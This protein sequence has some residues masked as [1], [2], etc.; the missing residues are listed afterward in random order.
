MLSV[1]PALFRQSSSRAR[2]TDASRDFVAIRDSFISPAHLTKPERWLLPEGQC[3]K[4]WLIASRGSW[5]FVTLEVNGKTLTFR[6]FVIRVYYEKLSHVQ[7]PPV[8]KF[9]PDLPARLKDVAEKQVPA[10]KPIVGNA[11]H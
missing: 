7:K 11:E 10:M 3:R 4:R 5:Q 6:F 9:R 1:E 8:P 2:V